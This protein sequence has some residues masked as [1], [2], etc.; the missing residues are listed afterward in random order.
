MTD[1]KGWQRYLDLA[2]GVSAVTRSAAEAAVRTLVARGEVAADRAERLVDDLLASSQDNRNAIASIV[3]AEAER[4]LLRFDPV[5][6]SDLDR[7]KDR[8][9]RLER[10]L[11]QDPGARLDPDSTPTRLDPDRSPDGDV[12]TDRDGGA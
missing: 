8:V 2:V 6:Q 3:R 1:G 11:G 12:D 9:D 5:H 7:L 4:A 10:R